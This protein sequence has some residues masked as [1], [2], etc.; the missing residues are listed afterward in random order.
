MEQDQSFEARNRR[1]AILRL[2]RIVDATHSAVLKFPAS[3][4]EDGT[5]SATALKAYRAYSKAQK[6]LRDLREHQ[7]HEEAEYQIMEMKA[8]G[9]ITFVSEIPVELL[10]KSGR[11]HEAMSTQEAK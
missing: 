11:I 9:L 1:H 6:E 5:A 10:I 4:F 3:E 2:E 7:G 8:K